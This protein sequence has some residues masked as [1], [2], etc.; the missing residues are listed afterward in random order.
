MSEISV[1]QNQTDSQTVL[2]AEETPAASV[3]ENA[4]SFQTYHI[5][6]VGI[7]AAVLAVTGPFAIPIGPV[8]IT[9]GTFAVILTGYVLGPKYGTVAV[10]VYLI[11]GTV[12]LPIFSGATG[13]F[14]QIIGPTG[15]Y[16]VGFLF[17][18]FFTGLFVKLFKNKVVLHAIG[19]VVGEVVLYILGTGWFVIITGYS[20]V[21]ALLVCVIPFL[22]G[23][24]IKLIAAVVVG[25]LLRRKLKFL[26][27]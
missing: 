12:G 23:D 20:V 6:L 10:A 11:L 17:L 5:A 27:Y 9:L 21:D 1:P 25:Y 18:A 4:G 8:S 19:A 7:L 16:L 14:G 22:I 13:G 15:G 26:P 3:R 2:P 24:T